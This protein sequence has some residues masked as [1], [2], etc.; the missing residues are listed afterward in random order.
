MLKAFAIT[1]LLAV[2]GLCFVAA[3]DMANQIQT[4]TIKRAG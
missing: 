2:A 1:L 4:M 3:G